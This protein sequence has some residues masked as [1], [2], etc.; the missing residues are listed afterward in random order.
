[1]LRFV[2]SIALLW[3]CVAC[4]PGPVDEAGLQKY[5]L[6]PTHGLTQTQVANGVSITV[7]YQPASLLAYVDAQ[8][9]QDDSPPVPAGVYA[10]SEYFLLTLSRQNSEVLK[11]SD[12]GFSNY[13]SLL[14]TLAF[15]LA[16]YATLATDLDTLRP[17]NSVL[18]R[19]FG[20]GA[21]TQIMLAFPANNT[22]PPI[23]RFC[24]REFGLGSGNLQFVFRG[25]DLQAIPRL[26]P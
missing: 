16:D 26:V 23:E 14:Q 4:S 6:D 1:M 24:L 10:Q 8:Q 22:H 21:G 20:M 17:S 12:T 18:D 9:S 15:R 5:L 25:Q 7:Q 2:L 19:T 3:G 11:P 13:S